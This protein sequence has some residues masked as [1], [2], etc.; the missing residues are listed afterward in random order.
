[1]PNQRKKGKKIVGVWLSESEREALKTISDQTGM[2]VADIIR[3]AIRNRTTKE[4]VK[5]EKED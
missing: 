3:E 4:N 5:D 2:S 1:M